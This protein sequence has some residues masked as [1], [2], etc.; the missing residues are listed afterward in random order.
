MQ[1]KIRMAPVERFPYPNLSVLPNT[2]KFLQEEWEKFRNNRGLGRQLDICSYLGTIWETSPLRVSL[3][4]KLALR[5]SFYDYWVGVWEW[6]RKWDGWGVMQRKEKWG[7][8]PLAQYPSCQTQC[9]H[10]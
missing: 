1:K 9:P 2:L 8:V 6:G 10:L 4:G 7:D 5:N 3:F